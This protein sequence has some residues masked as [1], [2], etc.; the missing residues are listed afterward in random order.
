M[1]HILGKIKGLRIED[2]K[3]VMEDDARHHSLHEMRLEHLWQNTEDDD[4]VF[5]LFK[6][7]DVSQA[8]RYINKIFFE[9][10]LRLEPKAKVHEII[11]LEENQN[12]KTE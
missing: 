8:K 11:F 6:A 3:S 10:T 4:E 5:F 2:V 7:H 1:P 12:H 9:Q